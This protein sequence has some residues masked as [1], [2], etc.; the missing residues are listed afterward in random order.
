MYVPFLFSLWIG[1]SAV[2]TSFSHYAFFSVGVFVCY[3]WLLFTFSYS[4][5][6]AIFVVPLPPHTFVL[7]FLLP[8]SSLNVTDHKHLSEECRG[9]AFSRRCTVLKVHLHFEKE[10][11]CSLFLKQDFH[12]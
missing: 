11:S 8:A 10:K 9:S 12:S 5:L 1:P 6:I 4:I 3:F 2:W 7:F